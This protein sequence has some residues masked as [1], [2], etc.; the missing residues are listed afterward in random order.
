MTTKLVRTALL[1][2]QGVSLRPG[3]CMIGFLPGPNK[4]VQTLPGPAQNRCVGAR[5]WAQQRVWTLPC[6]LATA[7]PSYSS[8]RQ[9]L[10]LAS[11]QPLESDDWRSH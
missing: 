6:Y 8:S 4:L 9:R 11:A 2:E 3:E 10:L 7:R 5:S 1:M